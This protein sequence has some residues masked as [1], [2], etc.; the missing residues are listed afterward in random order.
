M[1]FLFQLEVYSMERKRKS[2]KCAVSP[3]STSSCEKDQKRFAAA[4][5]HL[6]RKNKPLPLDSAS[7]SET[8]Q[9][10]VSN[11]EGMVRLF[12]S[13]G[14]QSGVRP[15]DIVGAIANEA[16]I[17]GKSIGAIEIYDRFSFV[18]VPDEYKDQVLA[19]MAHA[20]IRN[21]P[22]TMRIATRPSNK[23]D[24]DSGLRRRNYDQR[25]RDK[26]YRR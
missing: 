5:V 22:I 9:Q 23:S 24:R 26:F 16:N 15:R 17:P 4:A 10:S 18:D 25:R 8:K 12:I 11:E 1:K 7:R 20:T 19:R 2:R 21:E 3:N 6:A 14:H 13:I